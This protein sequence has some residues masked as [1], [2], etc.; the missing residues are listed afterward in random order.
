M[1]SAE[2]EQLVRDA[3]SANG[4]LDRLEIKSAKG[5]FQIVRVA[6]IEEE[7]KKLRLMA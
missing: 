1:T 3:Q 5:G 7:R 4:E 6:L 2:L